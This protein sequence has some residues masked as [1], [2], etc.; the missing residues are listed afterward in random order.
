MANKIQVK[1]SAVAGKIPT[2]ADL[3]LGEIA[4]NTYDGVAYIKKDNGTASIV[5]LGGGS[6]SGDVSGPSSSTDNALARFDGTTGKVIQNGLVTADD[7]GNIANVNSLGF[8]TTPTTTPTTEG[9]LYWDSAD[10]IQTLSLVMAGGNATQQIGQEQYYRIKASSTI[11]NGQVVMFSGTVGASG[12]LTGAPATGLTAAT[13]SYVMGIATQDIATNDWGYVT[14]FGLVRQIDA[15]AFTDGAILYLD[16]SVAGGLTATIPS[17]PNPKV[18]VCAV[19][20]AASNGSLFVRPSIGGT[21]GMFEGDVQVT[22]PA[23]GNL[24]VRDQTSGKWVNAALSAGTGLAITNGAGTVSVGADTGYSIPTTASQTNWDSAY[25]QR[26]QWDGGSTN[27]VASTGRTSLGA[28]TVGSNLF[29]LTNPSAITFPRFN[30]DNTV[31]SL[32]ASDF[33]AAIGAGTSSTTGTVTSITAG[34]GLSGGTITSSGTISLANT[35][36][37]AGSYTSANI[38]VD[39]QGR[40]TA[41][42]SGSGGGMVDGGTYGT[43]YLTN[44][45]RS[46]N[47]TGWY[48]QTYGGGI[49]MADTTYVRTYGSKQF[50]CDSTITAGGNV[51]AN[52]DETLKKNWRD[53]YPDF[54]DELSKVK[55]GTYDRIDIELTQDGVSAQ[56]LQKL[57][58][59]SV[60]QGSEGKLTVAYG[61]AA[62]VSAIQLAIRLID[63][64]ARITKLE[65]LLEQKDGNN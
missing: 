20:H 59:N 64:E 19:V 47:A 16:P 13:A 42:S 58:P 1:R 30:A 61:N 48:N 35:A 39:A 17:A 28:T 3:D 36:V 2:T 38:T 52:S 63:A 43:L 33:R 44:W 49:Y 57:L 9:S 14:S 65:K 55:H 31:S 37:T 11:T 25:T 23:N 54:V 26:L 27:L 53:F 40:I 34:T 56:S 12:G 21:L 6:G 18:Q 51:V 46:Y 29:T 5:Q 22:T 62:L 32:S 8:D 15:S 41:A 10:G 50:Y 4:I 45:F 24:L 7:N 60:M